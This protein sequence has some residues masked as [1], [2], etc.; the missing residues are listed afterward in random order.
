M[1]DMWKYW[2][3]RRGE[4]EDDLKIIQVSEWMGSESIARDLATEDWHRNSPDYF[5]EEQLTLVDPNG[6][7]YNY[8]IEVE[9]VPRFILRKS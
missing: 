3:P 7:I 4:T 9:S 5:E 1:K 2:W 6:I 8:S